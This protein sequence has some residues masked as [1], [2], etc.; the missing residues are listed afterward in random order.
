MYGSLSCMKVGG[1]KNKK[2]KVRH[3]R[4]CRGGLL[5]PLGV[6]VRAPL[7]C[8]GVDQIIN[9]GV[10]VFLWMVYLFV[11]YK[12]CSSSKLVFTSFS[13]WLVDGEQPFDEVK[14]LI[15]GM[16]QWNWQLITFRIWEKQTTKPPILITNWAMN[17]CRLFGFFYCLV[18]NIHI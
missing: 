10:C 12:T 9:E 7:L 15:L 16:V 1:C 3:L 2:L 5:P 13:Q 17:K 14:Q 8:N 18:G 4:P 6:F 11:V